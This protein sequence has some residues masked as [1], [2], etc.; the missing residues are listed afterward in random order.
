MNLFSPP[1]PRAVLFDLDGTLVDS[2]ADLYAAL[3]PLLQAENRAFP[4]YAQIRQVVSQ[5]ATAMLRV[6]WP[7]DDDSAIAARMPAFLDN[8]AGMLTT[9]T[10]LF[11]GMGTLLA[12]IEAAALPWGVV[13]NKSAALAHP[14]LA[15]LGLLQRAVVVVAG[16]TLAVKK[17]HPEPVLH[18]CRLANLVPAETLLVG[19]DRRDIEAGHSAGLRTVVVRWGYLGGDDPARLGADAIADQPED[20]AALLGL[21]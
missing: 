4:K 21:A 16:D 9:H 10:R 13:T 5:G 18:A 8:Y 2:A 3:L 20:V 1:W 12:R 19:D 15:D 6:A 7:D 17:P 14:L 11:P